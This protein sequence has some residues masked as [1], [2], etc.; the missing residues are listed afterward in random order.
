MINTYAEKNNQFVL[1]FI[2]L[3]IKRHRYHLLDRKKVTTKIQDSIGE[4]DRILHALT[5]K[6]EQGTRK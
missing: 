5:F 3:Y 4:R 1:T 2:S 6:D